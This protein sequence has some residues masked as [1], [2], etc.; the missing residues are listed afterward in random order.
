M[1][2]RVPILSDLEQISRLKR[3]VWNNS[4]TF[5]FIPIKNNSILGFSLQLISSEI[6]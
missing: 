3:E 5:A 2:S 1:A 6:D 4:D